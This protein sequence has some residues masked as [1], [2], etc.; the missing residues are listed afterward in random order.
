MAPSSSLPHCLLKSVT[1]YERNPA[2]LAGEFASLE[3]FQE[4][5][6]HPQ[7][8]YG[9]RYR[10]PP[11]VSADDPECDGKLE[12][13]VQFPFCPGPGC[14]TEIWL[15]Q[16]L[17]DD[18]HPNQKFKGIFGGS[19]KAYPMKRKREIKPGVFCDVPINMIFHHLVKEDHLRRKYV[20]QRGETNTSEVSAG[21]VLRNLARWLT[22]YFVYETTMIDIDAELKRQY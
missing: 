4:E 15:F 20:C 7:F 21:H 11:A 9:Y 19:I 3:S 8:K 17:Y 16:L 14:P 6:N 5:Y 12:I 1:W 10:R 22:V 2:L 13:S 18:N